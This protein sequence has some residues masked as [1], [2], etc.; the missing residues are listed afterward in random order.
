MLCREFVK[1]IV[2]SLPIGAKATLGS[3]VP[4]P[5]LTFDATGGAATSAEISRP[6]PGPRAD[7]GVR[8]TTAMS[9]G[10]PATTKHSRRS[11]GNGP[12][13]FATVGAATATVSAATSPTPARLVITRPTGPGG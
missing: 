8:F 10:W 4:G 12:A 2:P 1:Q 6:L 9:P 11:G 7:T 13:P 3:T 5:K